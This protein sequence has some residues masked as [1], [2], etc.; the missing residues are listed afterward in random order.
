M[1]FI[2]IIFVLNG[3][4]AKKYHIGPSGQGDLHF[5]FF[6]YNGQEDLLVEENAVTQLKKNNTIKKICI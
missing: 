3:A 1:F 6:F 4:N 2:I 5:F